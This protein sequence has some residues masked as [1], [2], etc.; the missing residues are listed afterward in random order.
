MTLKLGDIFYYI[1]VK[2][3]NKAFIKCILLLR[4]YLNKLSTESSGQQLNLDVLL[5]FIK[6]P[7]TKL[8]TFNLNQ[9]ISV[10]FHMTH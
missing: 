5:F 6:H 9:I 8:F 7:K 3:I 2:A 4:Y 1:L 10:R